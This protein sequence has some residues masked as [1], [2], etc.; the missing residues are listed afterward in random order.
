MSHLIQKLYCTALPRECLPEYLK[1]GFRDL[2]ELCRDLVRSGTERVTLVSPFW[3]GQ[4]I[5]L[6]GPSLAVAAARGALVRVVLD[7]RTRDG[8]FQ[9][10]LKSIAA[11]EGGDVV[12]KRMRVLKGTES[13]GFIH[14]KLILIDG[15]RGYLGSANLTVGGLERNFELG[16]ELIPTQVGMLEQLI[17][18][19]EAKGILRDNTRQ[20]I[21]C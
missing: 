15:V 12:I 14:T 4:G 11:A 10:A 5:E 7:A 3:S 13:F 1:L 2:D 18:V 8:D 19:F 16:V 21:P 9:A 17:A 20:I 6:L